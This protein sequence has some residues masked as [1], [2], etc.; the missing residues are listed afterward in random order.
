MDFAK[1]FT[2]CVNAK[3]GTRS[4]VSKLTRF[5]S[6]RKIREGVLIPPNAARAKSLIFKKVH[7]DNNRS[8]KFLCFKKFP[9]TLVKWLMIDNSGASLVLR[10]STSSLETVPNNLQWKELAFS[11]V[12]GKYQ[13]P[14][15]TRGMQ[16]TSGSLL[17]ECRL[18]GSCNFKRADR[19]RTYV[20]GPPVKEW[21]A[22]LHAF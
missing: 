19:V 3:Q 6:Y 2:A 18:W 13:S 20:V 10:E 14:H 5:V 1:I 4:F 22:N 7:Q 17:Q 11:H 9:Q 8:V 16:N 15:I 21:W 12:I